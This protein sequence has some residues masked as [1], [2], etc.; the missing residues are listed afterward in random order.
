MEQQVTSNV[1]GTVMHHANAVAAGQLE[2]V[3]RDYTDESAIITADQSFHGLEEIRQFWQVV[4]SQFPPEVLKTL[5][6]TRQEVD[7]NLLFITYKA[8]PV[9]KGGADTFL[10]HNGKIITHTKF[11][12]LA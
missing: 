3:M 4:F 7:G 8:D 9:V 12:V 1:V 6:V 2:E 10:V 11:L 5:T